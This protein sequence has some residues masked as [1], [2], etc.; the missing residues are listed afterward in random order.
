MQAIGGQAEENGSDDYGGNEL[1]KAD[2]RCQ[3]YTEVYA[4]ASN[5]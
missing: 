4:A 2:H 3:Q 5:G 1:A